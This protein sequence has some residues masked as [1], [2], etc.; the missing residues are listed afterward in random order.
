[1]RTLA[2]GRLSLAAVCLG[3]MEALRAADGPLCES[4]DDR[5]P[6][7]LANGFPVSGSTWFLGT[8]RGDRGAGRHPS[9]IAR[10]GQ[11]FP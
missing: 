10:S 1:M 2:A 8:I 3:G 7:L 5:Q 9:V 6:A 11:A 4:A